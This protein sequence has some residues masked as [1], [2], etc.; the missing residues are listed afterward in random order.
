[1]YDYGTEQGL[2]KVQVKSLDQNS[3]GLYYWSLEDK[4]VE[5][6]ATAR[7]FTG[8]LNLGALS[9]GMP[10]KLYF[11]GVD[12]SA[13]G[14]SIIAVKGRWEIPEGEETSIS[15]PAMDGAYYYHTKLKERNIEL[16]CILKQASMAALAAAE[17]GLNA[18]FNPHKGECEF[19]FD[20]EYFYTYKGRFRTKNVIETVGSTEIFNLQFT[21]SKPFIY[22]QSQYY[23]TQN[24]VRLLNRG[25]QKTPLRLTITGLATF[26]VISLGDRQ[27]NINTTLRNSTDIFIIDSEKLEI[28]LNGVSA[29]HLVEGTPFIYLDPGYTEL[30]ISTGNLELEF[31]ER[32]L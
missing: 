19:R 15:L 10:R 8:F 30:S 25:T 17:R 7:I 9:S 29:A 6:V 14:L 5:T 2:M 23:N 1:M 20:D 32:W 24:A 12:T 11:E 13:F 26:P 27:I 3:N 22:G 21:C 4:V 31:S 28:C 18:L 16:K